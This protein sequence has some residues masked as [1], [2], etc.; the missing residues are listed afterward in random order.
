MNSKIVASTLSVVAMIGIASAVWIYEGY[1]SAPEAITGIT[2]WFDGKQLT[3]MVN[4]ESLL[5]ASPYIFLVGGSL[6]LVFLL[7]KGRGQNRDAVSG[8]DPSQVQPDSYS[9]GTAGEGVDLITA[10]PASV[11]TLMIEDSDL[12]WDSEE[13][14]VAND[15]TR[16]ES[17]PDQDDT[18]NTL[19]V[20]PITEAKVYAACGRKAQAID[21]LVDTFSS[22]GIDHDA[23]TNELLT[24]FH[25]ELKSP[26][27]SKKSKILLQ[28]QRE[29]F[30]AKLEKSEIQLSDDTW[31][32]IQPDLP[33]EI[34]A[35][36]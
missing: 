7:F 1:G 4:L 18:P 36:A 25:Q 31:K 29:E 12:A 2:S 14:A 15:E 33:D 20:D 26:D 9:I 30:L 21:L 28:T 16:E 22:E 27:T 34:H 10:D 6:V 17:T 5:L 24:L 3:Q 23:A 32:R 13:N 19:R 8:A 35:V 11:T